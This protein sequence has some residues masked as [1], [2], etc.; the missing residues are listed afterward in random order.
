MTFKTASLLP[1][2]FVFLAQGI[3][4]G[5]SAPPNPTASDVTGNT[6]G[7]TE[8]LIKNVGTYNTAFGEYG[9]TANTTG[10]QNTSFG[11]RA[12]ISNTTGSHNTGIGAEALFFNT[13]GNDNTAT[14]FEALLSNTIGSYN[15]ANGY[16]ALYSNKIGN[17]NAAFGHGAL[18]FNTTGSYNSAVGLQALNNTTTGGL[19]TAV[20]Y[21]TLF[22]NKTG[23]GNIA[24]G[25]NAGYFLTA[26]SHNIYIGN[27]GIASES[28]S[29]RIGNAL[30]KQIFIAGIRGTTTGFNNAL[31]V[32]IDS[33][34]QLGT[35]SSSERFKKDIKDMNEASRRLFELRPV[36][37]HYK[38]N[39]EDGK[40]PLEYGL[41]AEE[42]AKIYPDLVVYGADGK[43]ETVQYQKLT[44]MLVNEVKRLNNLLQAEKD[45]NLAQTQEITNLKQQMTLLQAQSERIETLTSRLSR[46][47]ANQTLGMIAK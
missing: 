39:S 41:I 10:D 2:T 29:I 44:P 46:I 16:H 36:T 20:G 31:P 19:N 33:K 8:A 45:R 5:W 23:N 3:N 15:T 4:T 25:T 26:G 30:H 9:L 14:G 24:M 1:L 40:E 6:A 34:G 11:A 32:V 17:Y 42:V 12:L 43:V 21:N 27:P 47:E 18:R 35:I 13:G 7:G 37:Y 22:R 28:D 38:Q